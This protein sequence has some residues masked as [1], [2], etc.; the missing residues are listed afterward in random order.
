MC[1][2]EK[3]LTQQCLKV[4]PKSYCVWLHRQWVLER[5]PQPDWT[6][7]V[8]LCNLFLKYD[9]RNCELVC[10]QPSPETEREVS[11]LQFTAGTTGGLWPRRLQCR[12]PKSSRSP[13]TGLQPTSPTT[14]H[15]TTAVSSSPC[16]TPLPTVQGAW[17]RRLS[18]KVYIYV[19]ITSATVSVTF[20]QIHTFKLTEHEL[21]QNAFFTDPSDQSAWL[22]HRWLLGKT[23]RPTTVACVLIREQPQPEA[24]F[25]FSRP[26][27][28]SP[29]P[30]RERERE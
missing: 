16:S 3:T 17:P 18:Y 20:I 13:T 25:T 15:G 24:F 2:E 27:K 23:E 22:Y 14:P 8:S 10:L 21:A 29:C 4:N 12:P 9:E 1:G 28:V 11:S 7:E 26:T 19:H 6:S 30:V 5:S